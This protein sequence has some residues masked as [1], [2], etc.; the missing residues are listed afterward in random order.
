MTEYAMQCERL[1]IRLIGDIIF[2]K[3]RWFVLGEK[4]ARYG[5]YTSQDMLSWER[6]PVQ[7]NNYARLKAAGGKLFCY[8]H[9]YCGEQSAFCDMMYSDDG[10]VWNML[11]FHLENGFPHYVQDILFSMERWIFLGESQKQHDSFKYGCFFSTRNFTD[12]RMCN[13]SV[14][15]FDYNSTTLA[16]GNGILVST[17]RNL[18]GEQC[19]LYSD[20][21]S[22]WRKVV[23]PADLYDNLYFFQERL[24]AFSLD[25][26]SCW[27][28]SDALSW[29]FRKTPGGASGICK[30]AWPITVQRDLVVRP[31]L[32]EK[33]VYVSHDFLNWHKRELPFAMHTCAVCGATLFFVGS[34]GDIFQEKLSAL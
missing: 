17:A 21:L 20:D 13:T 32:S 7:L 6:V 12:W 24:F 22:S 9:P 29:D 28:S 34:R 19:V 5:L 11:P 15:F 25:L 27:V 1:P 2:F 26:S 18:A 8:R 30:A 10:L 4:D 33:A 31:A 23:V 14:D 16:Y 3:D